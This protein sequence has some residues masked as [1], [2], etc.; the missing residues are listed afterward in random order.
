MNR[1][2]GKATSVAR[3]GSSGTRAL[4]AALLMVGL[5][6][7]TAGAQS[8]PSAPPSLLGE[9]LA[10]FN[11]A[12][13][14]GRVRITA[15]CSR[16][17]TS[18]ISYKARGTATGPYAGAFT[19][20]GTYSIGPQTHAGGIWD[21]GTGSVISHHATFTIDSPLGQVTG[22]RHL[23]VSTS[24]TSDPR[25]SCADL[26]SGELSNTQYICNSWADER[27]PLAARL[28]HATPFTT[29]EATIQT[30]AG[31]YRDTGTA[32]GQ[33]LEYSVVCGNATTEHRSTSSSVSHQFRTSNGVRAEDVT[34]PDVWGTAASAPNAEGWYD[35][36]VAIAWEASDASGTAPNPRPSVASTEGADILYSSDETCDAAGNC[37]TGTIRLSID[38]TPPTVAATVEQL[39]NAH[40]WHR[41]DVVVTF[42]CEDA[43]SGVATCPAPVTLS[44]E[45]ADQEVTGTAVDA[46]GNAAT[47][48][49]S[50]IDIDHSGPAITAEL[51]TAPNA[52]GWYA[53]GPE[54]TFTC[55]DALSGIDSCSPPVTIGGEGTALSATGQAVD[56]AGN[57]SSVTISGISVDTT[58]PV[59]A[60]AGNAGTYS[61]DD[62]VAITCTATDELSGIS[63]SVCA[64]VRGPAYTFAV[65]TNAFSSEAVDAA[66]NRATETTTFD[67]V[68]TTAAVGNV[69]DDVVSSPKAANQLSS[70]LAKLEAAQGDPKK[71]AQALANFEKDVDKEIGKSLTAEDAEL[72]KALA[73]AL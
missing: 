9:R 24:F 30:S 38:K 70:T 64:D 59:V 40:G 12:S 18:T 17:G 41:A 35:D 22:T 53:S 27:R 36:D 72:L 31:A 34:P 55:S 26:E 54:V 47:V 42:A 25:G 33:L 60:Y 58:P 45:G 1:T 62:T 10:T 46:A 37:S 48:T 8:L 67:V 52:N 11:T 71:E 20:S 57:A 66:G 3:Q 14:Q 50:G 65:G 63:S 56:R 61:A 7:A 19:E 5:M 23:D 21:A 69:I 4:I 43:L 51:T 16:D 44:G 73:R 68:V 6:P 32:H 29:Y 39:P 15:S 49:L 28:W 2:V 13:D